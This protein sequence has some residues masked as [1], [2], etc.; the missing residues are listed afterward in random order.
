MEKIISEKPKLTQARMQLMI[1]EDILL[2]A[3]AFGIIVA[4]LMGGVA[5][6]FIWFILNVIRPFVMGS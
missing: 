3:P 4:I 1:T 6:F 5:F 2:R